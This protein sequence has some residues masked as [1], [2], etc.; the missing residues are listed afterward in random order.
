MK[1]L[2]EITGV[3]AVELT[4]E[5]LERI[6]KEKYREVF[7]VAA[8]LREGS[9]RTSRRSIGEVLRLAELAREAVGRYLEVVQWDRGERVL[10]LR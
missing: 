2:Q 9:P 5:E 7:K 8:R 10:R 1:Q 4:L 3:G 6:R